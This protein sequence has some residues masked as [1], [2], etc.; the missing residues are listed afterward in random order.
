ML[1]VEVFVL[2]FGENALSHYDI[3]LSLINHNA[4]IIIK[5][6]GKA[7]NSNPAGDLISGDPE[8]PS[9]E[10]RMVTGLAVSCKADGPVYVIVTLGTGKAVILAVNSLHMPRN[11]SADLFFA[12]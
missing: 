10:L 4:F 3:L 11:Y 9:A 2:R 1:D 12:C 6:V 5:D 7:I 8:Q